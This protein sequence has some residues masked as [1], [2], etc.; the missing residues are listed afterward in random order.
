MNI[1][2][3]TCARPSARRFLERFYPD[4]DFASCE[5]EVG[6]VLDL[7]EKDIFRI[8]DPDYHPD[9]G[10]F[11]GKNMNDNNKESSIKA[12]QDMHNALMASDKEPTNE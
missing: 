9:G 12:L 1:R 2:F 8:P 3:A 10:V 5:K 7:V 4:C 11:P 6:A